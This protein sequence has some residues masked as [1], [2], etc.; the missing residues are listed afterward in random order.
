VCFEGAWPARRVKPGRVPGFARAA[1][2][3]QRRAPLQTFWR[4]RH[5]ADPP[6]AKEWSNGMR[7]HVCPLSRVG[8]TVEACGAGR[9]VSLIDTGLTRPSSIA[10]RDHLWL[11]LHDIAEAREGMIMPGDAHVQALLEFAQSWDR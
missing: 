8:N 4:R 9:L 6:A 3:P 11:R 5:R 10:E 1:D 2:R 7:I